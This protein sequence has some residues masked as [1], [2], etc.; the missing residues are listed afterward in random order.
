[1]QEAVVNSRCLPISLKR[2]AF[3][4]VGGR[5]YTPK[6]SVLSHIKWKTSMGTMFNISLCNV[7]KTSMEFSPCYE[8]IMK[9]YKK[10]DIFRPQVFC[11]MTNDNIS[12]QNGASL[13][14][15]KLDR[16]EYEND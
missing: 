1:M 11:K 6:T 16:F 13:I 8:G 4:S 12:A 3:G 2:I 9:G 7:N 10:D 14:K 15:P 5:S